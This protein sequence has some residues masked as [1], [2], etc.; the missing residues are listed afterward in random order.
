MGI[1]EL[2]L[3]RELA[4]LAVKIFRKL[5]SYHISEHK[6]SAIYAEQW[7]K[8]VSARKKNKIFLHKLGLGGKQFFFFTLFF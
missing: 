1:Q 3:L 7:D 2:S 4:T 8:N 6:I 5:E